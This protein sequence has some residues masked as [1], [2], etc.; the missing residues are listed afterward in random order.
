MESALSGLPVPPREPPLPPDANRRSLDGRRLAA[1]LLDGLLTIPLWPLAAWITGSEI[2]FVPD[3]VAEALGP[4]GLVTVVGLLFTLYYFFAFEA[5]GGQTPGKRLL[6]LRELRSDGSEPGLGPVAV[7]TLARLID[8]SPIGLIVLVAGGRRRQRIGDIAAATIVTR[9]SPGRLF[10]E[11]VAGAVAAERALRVTPGRVV[12]AVVVAVVSIGNVAWGAAEIDGEIERGEASTTVRSFVSAA[13]A[14]RPSRACR[15][16]TAAYR[17]DL[18]RIAETRDCPRAVR[19]LYR[20]GTVDVDGRA[21]TRRELR[22]MRPKIAIHDTLGW[23]ALASAYTPGDEYMFAL[24]ESGDR[25]RIDGLASVRRDFVFGCESTGGAWPVC[26]CLYDSLRK[27]G[28]GTEK[29]LAAMLSR[30]Q[31]T[32]SA[33]PEFLAARQSCGLRA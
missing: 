13:T 26:S 31:T 5:Y 7:R 1:V 22:A 28:V 6:G 19:R 4:A 20:R 9:T 32:G 24:V 33:P 15:M 2:E 17:A 12:A 14:G 25:W 8:H 30:W 18:A 27:R 23:P 16:L 3:T 29:E 10:P 11:G 21:F